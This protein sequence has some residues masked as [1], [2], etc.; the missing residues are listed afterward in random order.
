MS[1]LRKQLWFVIVTAS[2]TAM[3]QNQVELSDSNNSTVGSSQTTPTPTL[4]PDVENDW[5]LL[6]PGVD[7]QNE[8]GTP[9]IKHLAQD[10]ATFWSSPLRMRSEN[11]KTA[12]PFFTFTGALI[13]SDSWISKQ[14]P[15]SP[16]QL[17]R[18]RDF[19]NVA[20][21]SLVGT[22][23]SGYVWGHITN[24]DHLRETGV[25]SAEAAINSTAV[26]FAFKGITQRP[27]PMDTNNG[28]A[29]FRGGSSFPSEHSAL[30]WSVA[31]VLAHEYPGPLTKFLAYGLASGI[32][33]SRV[34]S[35]DHFG[36]DAFIGSALGWYLGR[37]IYRAHHD[38]EIGGTG[39]GS[40]SPG[41]PSTE[42]RH[43]A[44]A[45]P[46]VPLDSWIY[47]ALG[48]LA[49][50]GYLQT[51][52]LGQRPWTRTECARLLEEGSGQIPRDE[53]HSNEAATTYRAL[54]EE[55][56]AEQTG[57]N[58]KNLSLRLDSIYTRFT[59]ISGPPLTDGYNFGR[60]ITNDHGRPFQEGTNN[61]SGLSMSGTVGPLAFYFRGEYQHSPFA[62]GESLP[63]RQAIADAES[64]PMASAAPYSEINR[65]RLV[66]GYVSLALK[67]LQFSFGKQ[68]L[69]W[70]P[71]ETG[72]LLASTNAEP[73]TMLRISTGEPFKLPSILGFLGPVR[74][75]FFIGQLEGQQY[76]MN[77]NGVVGPS[78]FKPQPFIHGQKFSFKPTPNLEFGFSRTVIF[79]GLG[80]PFTFTSFSKSFFGIGSNNALDVS[81]D[82]GDR[83]SGFDFNYKLPHLRKWLSLYS[84]SFCEDDVSP[85]AAPH[86]CAWSP[87]LYLAKFPG[88]EKLDF[89]AEGVYTDSPGLTSP[90][91]NYQ[92]IIY[93][94]GYTNYG[95]I[96]GSW[97]GRQGTGVQLWSTYWLSPQTK[98]QAGY[99]H[100]S[101]DHD[102]LQGG[103]LN[104]FSLRSDLMLRPDLAFSGIA[105]YEN[106]NF[107]LLAAGTQSNLSVSMSLTFRPRWGVTH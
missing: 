14:V 84:D 88:L 89:R 77:K 52:M 34:T 1:W 55:F 99:R 18:S 8:F 98:I 22:V 7:P 49:A 41:L 101:V 4:K 6:P 102:F 71:T 35:K 65:A 39:W 29:F 100:Q 56:L 107:P 68:S 73:I 106:W 25:L 81:G 79:S 45:S 28:S 76:I 70:G 26:A 103:N 31:S 66:E 27:G 91:T 30:A 15:D 23:G 20:L 93:R 43:V 67:N 74:T 94:S 11:L 57:T 96:I 9:F 36:S 42:G 17:K 64:V 92:N 59:E 16:G 3:A 40:S 24:N 60:T 21:L 82:P 86:R 44:H 97:I 48:R 2:I 47:P 61:Y 37:Q 19:S 72:P 95:N 78:A 51:S 32:T 53:S 104:D 80:H 85:L 83:R 46:Y 87:G 105:Q 50:W 5:G 10:Q 33:V 62:P 69:W 38:P 54:E 58:G 90:G 75:E 12:V 63:V 13:A